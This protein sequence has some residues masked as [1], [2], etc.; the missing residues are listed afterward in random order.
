MIR[1]SSRIFKAAGESYQILLCTEQSSP[2][3]N[4]NVPIRQTFKSIFKLLK[5]LVV[6]E[7]IKG[8]SA[9][10]WLHLVVVIEP[11]SVNRD[12]VTK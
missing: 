1:R 9:F 6:L 2:P 5:E 7:W 3:F 12:N 8:Q 10:V 11:L 4:F